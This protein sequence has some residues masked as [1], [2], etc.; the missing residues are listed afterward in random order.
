MTG[1]I[2]FATPWFLRY[3]MAT[4]AIAI[5]AMDG[6][7]I[8][9]RPLPLEQTGARAGPLRT[10]GTQLAEPFVTKWP[11]GAENGI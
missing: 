10:L 9:G 8:A 4:V 7:G 1:S 5:V 6:W 2:S 3:T 11:S